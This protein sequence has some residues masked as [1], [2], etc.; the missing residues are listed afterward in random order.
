M[1]LKITIPESLDDIKVS[2]YQK[3][4]RTTDKSEDDAFIARQLV[5]I[6]CNI[7][8]SVVDSIKATDYKSIVNTIKKVLEEKPEFNQRFK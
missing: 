5:G 8:D 1:K 4:I 6:F 2:Q 7:P 3:F